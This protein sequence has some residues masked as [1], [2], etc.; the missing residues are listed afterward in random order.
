M[1]ENL[2]MSLSLNE[3]NNVVLNLKLNMLNETIWL[4]EWDNLDKLE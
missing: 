2:F 1:K 3:K 4:L